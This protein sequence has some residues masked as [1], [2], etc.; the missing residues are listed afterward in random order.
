MVG[1]KK[2]FRDG[3]KVD[4]K[5]I[6][7]AFLF[8]LIVVLIIKNLYLTKIEQQE[9]EKRLENEKKLNESVNEYI[10]FEGFFIPEQRQEAER[11]LSLM[12]EDPDKGEYYRKLGGIYYQS[13]IN[14]GNDELNLNSIKN[15]EKAIELDAKDFKAY[16]GLGW[17]YIN[18]NNFDAAISAFQKS[19]DINFG[20][21]SIAGAG[22]SYYETGDYDKAIELFTQSLIIVESADTLNPKE[23]NAYVGLGWSYY[24]KEDFSKAIGFFNKSDKLVS[25]IGLIVSYHSM[26][27]IDKAQQ[28]RRSLESDKIDKVIADNRLRSNGVRG[29]LNFDVIICVNQSISVGWALGCVDSHPK[30][31]IIV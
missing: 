14:L 12:S 11:L 30:F 2:V 1:I 3:D 6:I 5:N 22:W 25:Q 27:S 20:K 19:L 8:V 18:Q 28:L 29:L 26:G 7:I 31:G 21:G 13:A 24:R 9:I 10:R 4:I 15:F 17:S 16:E 23:Y